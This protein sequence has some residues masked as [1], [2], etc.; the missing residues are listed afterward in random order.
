M[1]DVLGAPLRRVEDARL[2]TGRGRYAS[3]L[4]LER[5]VYMAVVRSPLA[6]ARIL[7][8]DL[9]AGS[10]PGVLAILTAADLDRGPNLIREDMGP[11][12]LLGFGRPVLAPDVVRY[13]GEAIAVVVAETRYVAEDVASELYAD[14]EPLPAVTGVDRATLP[15]APR[16]HEQFDR[17]V[18]LSGVNSYG[19]IDAAFDGAP[20]VV[21]GRFFTNRV[22]GAAIEPRAVTA[23]PRGDGVEIWC[24]TQHVFGVRDKAATFLGLQPEQVLVRA[25]DVGGGFGPKGRVYPEELL[26]AFAA[27]RLGRPVQWVAT[28]SEDT[29]TT[30]QAH[31]SGIEIE[32]AAEPD[33]RLRGLRARIQHDLGA[34]VS[35]GAGIIE[36]IIAHMLSGYVLEAFRVDYDLCFTNATPTGTIRGGGR[37]QG[38]FATE[39]M[40]DRLALE[41]NLDP[42]ELRR[43]NLIQPSQMPYD[44]GHSRGG[45]RTVYD[46]GDYPRLLES[47]LE[48]AQL[49]Q[50]RPGIQPDGTVVGVG[51]AFCVESTGTGSGEPARTDIGPDGQ[52][53]LYIGSSPG[54]QGHQTMAAQ[55]MAHRL[56]WPMERITVVAGDT[57]QLPRGGVTA[58]SRSAVHVGNAV[59]LVARKARAELLRLASERLE[60]DPEDLELESGVVSVRGAPAS[61]LSAA[62]L[63]PS[64]GLSVEEAFVTDSPTVYASGCHVAV[65]ELDPQTGS[66]GVLRYAIAHDTGREINPRLV[67]GQLHGGLVHGLGYALLEE[68]LYDQDGGFLS[69]TFLDYSIA[70]APDFALVPRH[71]SLDTLS[72]A[73]PEGIKGAGEGATIPAPAAVANAVESALRLIRPDAFVDELP[74]TPLRVRSWIGGG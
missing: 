61:S 42:A 3:D 36:I 46:S 5:Q 29:A 71:R 19:D 16:V 27:L 37:P 32:L 52:V 66:V 51:V 73:N 26:A 58:A 60:V 50:L 49:D 40:M 24:S 8:I 62:D 23:A 33:G 67:E 70:S 53:R 38:N 72:R 21:R 30:V 6:H 48:L 9:A 14:L 64:A 20:V 15:G 28:R 34:Y 65:I 41:L 22:C 17:N 59:S 68:A 13:Q 55:I 31:G 25:E 2:V 35:V 54:G 12:E 45:L 69:T 44:T 18:A 74:I 63:I 11:P 7:G 56:G 47:A 4:R 57:S 43:R 39:R 10:R 1:S